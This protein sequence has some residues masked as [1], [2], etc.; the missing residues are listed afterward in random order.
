MIALYA[1]QNVSNEKKTKKFQMLVEFS[2][3]LEI[4]IEDKYLHNGL[5]LPLQ[6]Y[7]IHFHPKT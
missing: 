7:V 3:S 4:A 6:K 2:V 5:A 1:H